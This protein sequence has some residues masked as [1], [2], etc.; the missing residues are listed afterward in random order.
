VTPTLAATSCPNDDW[1]GK[2]QQS[3]DGVSEVS[4]VTH[5]LVPTTGPARRALEARRRRERDA[6]RRSLQH[7]DDSM[8]LDDEAPRELLTN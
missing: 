1:V 3:Q 4:R 2:A 6:L 8:Q 5:V 7:S